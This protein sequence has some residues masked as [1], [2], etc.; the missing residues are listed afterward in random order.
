M[1]ENESYE[2]IFMSNGHPLGGKKGRRGKLFTLDTNL[3]EQAHRYALFNSDCAEVNDY[4]NGHETYV[5]SQPQQSRSRDKNPA[6][7][8]VDY[9]GRILDI[10][11]LD[12]WAKFR[13]VLFHCEWYQVEKD[14][15]G[16]T[17]VN[18]KKQCYSD[19][20][21]VMPSQV[22]QVFYVPDPIA[23]DRLSY[24]AQPNEQETCLSSEDI[25]PLIVEASTKLAATD[26]IDK[27]NGD[28]YDYD[29]T[30]WDWMHTD[31]NEDN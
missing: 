1:G 21:F 20:P 8:N 6:V 12:Y 22:K 19:D 14:D 5:E 9:Y 2:A 18:M 17:C 30:L 15:Y 23:D 7:G 10:I 11:E 25:P 28:D 26:V 31:E 16:L 24:T 4:F 27:D 3:K 13:V 29:D